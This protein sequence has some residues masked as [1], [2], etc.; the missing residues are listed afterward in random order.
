MNGVRDMRVPKTL[1]MSCDM[2][3]SFGPY[4]LGEDT[5]I[6]PFITS[7]SIACGF[8][9]GD[10]L[11]MRHTVQK[12]K[13]HGVSIG[14]HPGYPDLMG[15]GRRMLHTLPGEIEAY[16]L[17][18]MGALNAFARTAGVSLNYVKPHGALYNHVA[19]NE[20]AARE[21][22]HAIQSQDAPLLLYMLSGSLCSGMA[23]A[24]GI[25]VIDEAFPDRGYLKDG[26]LAP[27]SVQ[28]AVIHQVPEVCSRAVQLAIEGTIPALDG[29]NV[30]V[31][32]G[33]LCVHGDTPGAWIMAR[34]MSKALQ[35][36]GIRIQ[37]PSPG[38]Q[39]GDQT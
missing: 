35:A 39:P 26:S 15:F 10:P 8:H 33:T 14:A 34:E 18:Q 31:K 22:I 29:S 7:A 17:Y 12:A 25:E 21:L 36:K 4:T 38:P 3:E 2:G 5:R 6:M 11:V 27:R 19:Q 20:Q 32:A 9:G 30:P 24:A 28:G 23:R 13:E 16:V 37:A 1:D